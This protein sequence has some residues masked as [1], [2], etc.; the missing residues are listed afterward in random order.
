MTKRQPLNI[1]AMSVV[2]ESELVDLANE[3]RCMSLLRGAGFSWWDII[4]GLDEAQMV[5]RARRAEE[6][7][8][9]SEEASHA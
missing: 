9:L 1:H 6:A 7:D 2:L 3:R 5:A 4:E 8:R